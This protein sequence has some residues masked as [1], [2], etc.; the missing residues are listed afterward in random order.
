MRYITISFATLLLLQA[1]VAHAEQGRKRTSIPG[2]QF[3]PRLKRDDLLVFAEGISRRPDNSG[4]AIF[5]VSERVKKDGYWSFA[6]GALLENSEAQ[7]TQKKATVCVQSAGNGWDQKV[8]TITDIKLEVGATGGMQKHLRLRKP[9]D[10][11]LGGF[12][13]LYAEVPIM[14]FPQN[15]NGIKKVILVVSKN[16]SWS[17]IA[18]DQFNIAD[19]VEYGDQWTLYISEATKAANN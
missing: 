3:A 17:L 10:R 13:K 7:N 19:L 16:G 4:A 12:E 1:Q 11:M 2:E 18:V 9:L 15:K 8:M 6:T 5:L 14:E